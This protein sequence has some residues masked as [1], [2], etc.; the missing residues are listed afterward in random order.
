[1]YKEKYAPVLDNFHLSHIALIE[2]L[3]LSRITSSAALESF[4]MAINTHN[5]DLT[6][7]LSK[8]WQ[9]TGLDLKAIDIMASSLDN[10]VEPSKLK[11]PVFTQLAQVTGISLS[12]A[13]IIFLLWS[14]IYTSDFAQPALNAIGID[15][16]SYTLAVKAYGN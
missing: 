3:S 9:H 12:A 13:L 14:Y 1:M 4:S 16:T 10:A 15:R 7:F 11:V 8:I 6:F 2:Q 5:F